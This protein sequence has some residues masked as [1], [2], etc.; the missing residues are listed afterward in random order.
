MDL[1]SYSQ[2]VAPEPEPDP[3]PIIHYFNLLDDND[4]S[5]PAADDADSTNE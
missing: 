4:D 1:P 5:T 3:N 2:Q